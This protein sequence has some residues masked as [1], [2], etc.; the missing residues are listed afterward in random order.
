MCAMVSDLVQ[1]DQIG[2]GMWY[3]CN[4]IIAI[5][6]SWEHFSLVC[7][8]VSNSFF[9]N[10]QLN[11]FYDKFHVELFYWLSLTNKT[12]LSKT[13]KID[14]PKNTTKD[15]KKVSKPLVHSIRPYRGFVC[16][17]KNRT[18]IFPENLHWYAPCTRAYAEV[19]K[20]C[21]DSAALSEPV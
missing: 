20:N 6:L 5:N 2:L 17:H 16:I 13:S 18:K 10:K 21:P 14:G 8:S 7:N 1:L 3:R 4:N 19:V 11:Q 15:K 9:V 12:K